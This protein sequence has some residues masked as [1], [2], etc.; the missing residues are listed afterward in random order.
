MAGRACVRAL[1][2]E[3]IAELDVS[4]TRRD[5]RGVSASPERSAAARES[6]HGMRACLPLGI[7]IPGWI[8]WL[9]PAKQVAARGEH[10]CMRFSARVHRMRASVCGLGSIE[11][12]KYPGF[13]Q[14]FAS[15]T[16]ELARLQALPVTHL[17][18][19]CPCCLGRRRKVSP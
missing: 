9:R 4:A 10:A 11:N 6:G 5:G 13:A 17:R 7:R 16:L 1:D 12:P 2:G 3:D 15:V 8:R 19:L 18:A 14:R